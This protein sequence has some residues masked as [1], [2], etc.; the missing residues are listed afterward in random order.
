MTFFF[1]PAKD[2]TQT[3]DALVGLVQRI[4]ISQSKEMMPNF[5]AIEI[6][7]NGNLVI[8]SIIR[9]S[10]PIPVSIDMAYPREQKDNVLE[11]ESPYS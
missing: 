8:I 1:L 4:A 5:V 10:R 2:K 11:R 6:G 9:F 3:R 7:T